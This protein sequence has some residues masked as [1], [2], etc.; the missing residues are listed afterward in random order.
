MM[1]WG[2][3]WISLLVQLFLIAGVIYF[4]VNLL[5]K[6]GYSNNR[7]SFHNAEMILSER[8]ARGEIS[9]EEYK[10]MREVL[11]NGK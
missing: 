7:G 6:D 5:K 8:Y 11:R 2:M 1:G 9:E 3:G 4:L 10:R